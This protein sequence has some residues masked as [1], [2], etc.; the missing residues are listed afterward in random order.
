M[1]VMNY[2]LQKQKLGNLLGSN[3]DLY[4]L[5]AKIDRK[6]TYGENKRI[7]LGEARSLGLFKTKQTRQEFGSIDKSQNYLDAMEYERTRKPKSQI[8]DSKRQAKRVF[9]MDTLNKRNY[10]LWRKSPNKYDIEGIDT[11][12]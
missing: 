2:N 12:Y 3:K 6:L 11:R 9:T 7:I 1:R 10:S 5:H 8:I 4:D